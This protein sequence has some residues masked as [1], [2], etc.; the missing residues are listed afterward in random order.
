MEQHRRFAVATMI[1]ML[2]IASACS[3]ES[4]TVPERD[5]L[6]AL[7]SPTTTGR[8][9]A[10]GAGGA[11]AS[12]GGGVDAGSDVVTGPATPWPGASVVLLPFAAQRGS[13]GADWGSGLTDIVQHL[14]TTYGSQYD[15]PSD[16]ITW[17]HETTHGINSHLRNYLNVTGKQAN[18][19]Y[20]MKDRF[21]LVVE[22]SITLSQ[23]GPKVPASLRGSRYQTYLVDQVTSWNDTPTYVMDEWVAYTNGSEVGVELAAS[24]SWTTWRDG[25][26]GTLEFTIYTLALAAAVEAADPAYFAG[27]TQ[28]REFIAFHAERAMG[29]YA[30]GSKM[31]VFAWASQDAYFAAWQTSSDAKQLRNAARR[32]FGGA[33]ATAVLGISAAVE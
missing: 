4:A 28:F 33:Y 32:W 8:P 26:A 16:R 3:G 18:G 30:K 27:Y 15:Y 29:L 10:P 2:G 31:P 20:L 23:V 5:G 19:F 14:P 22:P 25:V 12:G 11:G 13:T 1:G 7:P 24:G 21:A 9:G 6:S 17:A